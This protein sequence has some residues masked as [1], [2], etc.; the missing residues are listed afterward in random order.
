MTWLMMS[1]MTWP[2]DVADDVAA[3]AR[4]V[5]TDGFQDCEPFTLTVGAGVHDF[6]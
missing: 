1:L 5:S 2:D 3:Q 6:N 4:A